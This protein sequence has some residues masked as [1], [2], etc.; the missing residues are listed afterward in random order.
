MERYL[1]C[2]KE[3]DRKNPQKVSV[4]YEY[5]REEAVDMNIK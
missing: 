4:F 1:E 5:F 3:N 2:G